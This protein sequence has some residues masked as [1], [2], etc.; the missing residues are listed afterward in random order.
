MENLTRSE[1]IQKIL[2]DAELQQLF[3]EYRNAKFEGSIIVANQIETEGE[4]LCYWLNTQ[5]KINR[6]D[7]QDQI[8]KRIEEIKLKRQS[9]INAKE[10][11]KWS[12]EEHK[13]GSITYGGMQDEES[14]CNI[15]LDQLE[16]TLK[17]LNT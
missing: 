15:M 2:E 5:E 16:W 4:L 13:N 12:D 8:K 6:L 10:S 7:P 9:I 3:V 11:Y 1:A 17:I 14:K